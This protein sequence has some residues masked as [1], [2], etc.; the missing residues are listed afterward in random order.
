MQMAFSVQVASDLS[1]EEEQ[2]I[3]ETILSTFTEIHQ[4]Y[5]N[6]NPKSEVSQLANL[7][8]RA[9]IRLSP[10]LAQFLEKVDQ[11]VKATDGR[12]DPTIAPLQKLW[13]DH[14]NRGTLPSSE[15]QNALANAI[16]WE[17]IHLKD[18]IFWKDHDLTA[19]D[20]CGV[21]KG[22]GV[23]L[24]LER[25]NQLGYPNVYVE[26]GGEIHASGEKAKNTPWKIRVVD[27]PTL[28][29][30]DLAIATSGSL[31]QSWT[32]EETTYTHI[33]DPKTHRPLTNAPASLTILA[34]TCLEADA[35]AT[36][37]MLFSSSEAQAFANSHSL[38][39]IF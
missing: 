7:K 1:L 8:A 24:I 36:A 3:E 37:L 21:A 27:G 4:V 33:L 29:L 28:P 20:L 31:L 2:K 19:L 22:Y 12:F 5:N 34:P 32:I 39:L 10:P 13:C 14:L 26:W 16:G 23:D 18:G 38:T 11:I 35:Y 17:K 25:V 30:S 15:E 9:P 6:W